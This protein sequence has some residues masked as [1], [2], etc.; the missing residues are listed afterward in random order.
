MHDLIILSKPEEEVLV[1]AIE[2]GMDVQHLRQLFVW[3]QGALSGLLPHRIMVCIQLDEA[4]QAACVECL[5]SVPLDP[6]TQLRLC[7]ASDGLAV[8]LAA[9]CRDM[10]RLSCLIDGVRSEPLSFEDGVITRDRRQA[11]LGDGQQLAQLGHEVSVLGLRNALV[12]GTGRLPGG[13]AYFALFQVTGEPTVRH[14]FFL[15]LMLPYLHMAFMRVI[16]NRESPRASTTQRQPLTPRELEVL[17][18]VVQGKSNPEIGLILGLSSLTVKNHLQKIYRK[19]DVHNR[20]QALSRCN[21]LK[22]AVP[23][24]DNA[25]RVRQ[26][27]SRLAAAA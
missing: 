19:L 17:G 9:H 18:W 27:N 23:T 20:V 16:V 26:R 4:G 15:S 10:N 5:N 21:E 13:S 14:A 12:H 6:V 11:G 22:L 8:R 24:S 7:D 3:C 25:T 2:A 1:R